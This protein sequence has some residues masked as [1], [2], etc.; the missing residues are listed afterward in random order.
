MTKKKV[1]VMGKGSLAIKIAN[2]FLNSRQYQLVGLV[3][4]VPEPAWSDSLITWAKNKGIFYITSGDYQDIPG[5]ESRGWCIDLVFSVFYDKIIETDFISRCKQILNLHNGPLPKYRGVRPINWALK[6]GEKEH[7]VTIHE[8]TGQ[9]DAGPIITQIKFPID[10]Q[11]D[12][13][14]DVY[15]RSLEYGWKLFCQT[16]PR[17]DKIKP[18]PQDDLLSSYYSHKDIK[19]LAER[20]DFSRKDSLN[21]MRS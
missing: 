2:W 18:M 11:V 8:I 5:T 4:V 14:I 10:P 20:K 21:N 16:M 7:G 6:N 15:N 12:E 1:I 3:P 9:I 19:K 17:L 13:V